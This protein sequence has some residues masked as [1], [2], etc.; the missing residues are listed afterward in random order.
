MQVPDANNQGSTCRHSR[1]YNLSVAGDGIFQRIGGIAGCR[2]LAESLYARIDRDPLLKPL[3][4]GKTHTCAIE[5]FTAFLT[6][7]LEGPSE[8]TQR[9][10]WLSLDESHR[11][12]QIGA[13]ERNA[14]LKHMSAA[15][16]DVPLEQATRGALRNYFEHAS[17]YLVNQGAATP[18]PRAIEHDGLARRWAVQREIDDTMAA[19]RTRDKERAIALLSS[20]PVQDSV[21]CGLLS[22]MLRTRALEFVDYV[23]A[24]VRRDPQL[25]RAVYNSRTLL[26]T[27]AAAGA[28]ATVQFLLERGAE[29][30]T[31]GHPPLYSLANEFSGAGGG[32]IVRLLVKAGARVDA[33]DNV[34][35]CTALHM[36]ARRGH[37]EIATALLDCGADIEARDSADETPL[38]RAVNCNKTEVA[39][40]LVARG[41]DAHSVG[42]KGL[43]P[44]TAARSDVMRRALK[45][46]TV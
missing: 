34:K 8:H 2:R 37:V 29:P 5:E 41:A 13:R 6:Q 45:Q 38:R 21:R 17:A 31:S 36:A 46:S 24:E 12:F 19:I 3:F 18:T 32:E 44:L 16:E 10:W 14:W 20:L 27:A 28:V 25:V 11:R 15:L 42:S 23:H 40:L 35:R 43:T 1:R 4:P 7:F 9:R 26:H 30:N 39:A 22:E 33:C